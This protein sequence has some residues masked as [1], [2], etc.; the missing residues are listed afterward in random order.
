MGSEEDVRIVN[1]ADRGTRAAHRQSAGEED[2]RQLDVR[3]A[4]FREGLSS[5]IEA[6]AGRGTHGNTITAAAREM[7]AAA[8]EVQRG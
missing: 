5:R 8:V 4:A 1:S 6:C 2:S 7:A 3:T